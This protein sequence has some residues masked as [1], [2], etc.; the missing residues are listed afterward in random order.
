L[1]QVNLRVILRTSLYK[2]RISLVGKG[3]IVGSLAKESI[4]LF[5]N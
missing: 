3:P 1:V 5:K 2:F 4:D